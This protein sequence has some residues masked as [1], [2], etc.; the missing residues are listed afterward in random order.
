MF[1][2][3]RSAWHG[4]RQEPCS[5]HVASAG[6]ESP[7]N[8]HGLVV[9]DNVEREERGGQG[10]ILAAVAQREGGMRDSR[11]QG[12]VLETFLPA[13]PMPRPVRAITK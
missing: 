4:K 1:K 12:A 10:G 8:R 7:T 2:R 6:R 13:P 5:V 11:E 3:K 9:T